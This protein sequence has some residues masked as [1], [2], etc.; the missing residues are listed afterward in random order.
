MSGSSYIDT[1]FSYLVNK[2][3]DSNKISHAY[4]IEIKDYERDFPLIKN[5]AKMILCKNGKKYVDVYNCNSCNICSLI[6]SNNYPDLYIIEPDGKEIKKPQL[7]DL[8]KEFLN[9]SLLDNKRIYILREAEKLNDSAANT[10]LKFLEE[11][12]DDIVAILVTT[13]RYKMLETILSRCQVLTI[14]S[15]S[16]DISYDDCVVDLIDYIASRDSLFINY[17]D[18]LNNIIPDKI[19]AFSKLKLIQE[20]FV[21]YLINKDSSP[22]KQILD[23]VSDKSIVRYTLIIDEYLKKLEYNVNYKLW[24]DSLFASLLGGDCGV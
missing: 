10:I 23:K 1:N 8:Q 6:D 9:K 13:N 21:S 18:I 14:N 17:N 22:V 5:F 16:D 15:S 11:P 2:I 3:V 19:Q 4:I 24:L 20:I 12:S 7:L